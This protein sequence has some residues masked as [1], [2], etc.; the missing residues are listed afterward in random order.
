M[1]K[2]FIQTF[3]CQMNVYDRWADETN[4]VASDY[5]FACVTN[6]LKDPMSGGL[7][8]SMY[9]TH[10]YSILLYYYYKIVLMKLSFDQ[11]SIQIDKDTDEIEELIIKITN[12]SSKYY[13]PEVNSSTV[14]KDI[15][16]TVRRVF[17][18]EYL[19]SHISSSL[20]TLYQNQDKIVSKRQN[21]L[22]QTLT[23]C[24]VSSSIFGMNLAIQDWEGEIKW[25]QIASYTLFEWFALGVALSGI[26]IGL[27]L[28]FYFFS[29]WIKEKIKTKTNRY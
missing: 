1:K 9:G 20:E 13:F 4:F 10:F 29:G 2:F 12:F 16:D 17:Q 8:S 6:S 27:I 5:T 18:L 22:L 7:A 21:Y 25:E 19:Y 15:Y 14:G 26:I 24:T 11:S 23:L 28:A 3:G